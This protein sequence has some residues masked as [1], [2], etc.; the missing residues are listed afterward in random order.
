MGILAKKMSRIE[1]A[2]PAAIATSAIDR[3]LIS[4]AVGNLI[5][6]A[7]TVDSHSDHYI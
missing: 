4:S 7:S 2:R 3:D 1:S 5:D 6:V